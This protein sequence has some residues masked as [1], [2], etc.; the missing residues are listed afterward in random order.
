MLKNL[1]T[2]ITTCPRRTDFHQVHERRQSRTRS[3][4]RLPQRASSACVAAALETDMRAGVTDSL[5]ALATRR[6]SATA[7]NGRVGPRGGGRVSASDHHVRHLRTSTPFA[8][9]EIDTCSSPSCRMVMR[10]QMYL[11]REHHHLIPPTGHR[12][13]EATHFKHRH[14]RPRF[15]SGPAVYNRS[16]AFLNGAFSEHSASPVAA[17]GSSTLSEEGKPTALVVF[18]TSSR[19]G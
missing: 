11:V 14:R 13:V 17:P 16:K 10:R 3:L 12:W 5:W 19:A 7:R 4:V 8:I 1:R 18:H 2:L 9:L 15:Q 6:M